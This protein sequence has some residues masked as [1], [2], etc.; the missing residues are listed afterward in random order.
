MVSPHTIL[1]AEDDENDVFFLKRALKE[2]G[3]ETQIFVARDGQEAVNY[4]SGQPPFAN[5]ADFPVPTLLLLDLKMPRMSGFDVLQWL[6]AQKDFERLLVVV[7]SSSSE[8]SD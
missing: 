5:R 6:H 3:L 4:L 8:E 2:A 1:L 7:F